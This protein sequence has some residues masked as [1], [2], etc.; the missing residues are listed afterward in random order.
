[1]QFIQHSDLMNHAVFVD[2][3]YVYYSYTKCVIAQKQS[4]TIV[5][6]INILCSIGI[7][8]PQHACEGYSSCYVCL[9]VCLSVCQQLF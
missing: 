7:V 8:N 1:M 6:N 2:I 9:S 4:C 5:F 3:R